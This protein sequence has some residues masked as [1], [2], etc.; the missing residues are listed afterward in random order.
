L[1]VL[2]VVFGV[3][4]FQVPLAQLIF[5]IVEVTVPGVWWSGVA[6]ALILLAVIVGI[7]LY[8]LTMRGGKLRRV[9]TYI[10]GEQM[11]DVYISNDEPGPQRHVEVTGVDFY[12]TIEQIPGL[13]KYYELMKA[14]M[15]DIYD[16]FKSGAD[17]VVQ[18]LR[19]IHTGILPAYTRWFVAGLLL[20]VWVVTMEGS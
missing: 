17:Y 20:V 14:R 8:W 15:F 2:C 19:S 4:A 18:M 3:Y 16:L 7:G 9:R 10:G 1:A 5:P 6:T 11:Q 12:D 13:H